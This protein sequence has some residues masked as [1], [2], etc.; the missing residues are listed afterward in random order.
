M[1]HKKVFLELVI[2]CKC[3]D[4][5]NFRRYCTVMSQ[6]ECVL[7]LQSIPRGGGMCSSC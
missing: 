1:K 5:Y 7:V 6:N 2:K 4:L 3:F